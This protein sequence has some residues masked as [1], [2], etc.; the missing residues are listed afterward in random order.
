MYSTLNRHGR[1]RRRPPHLGYDTINLYGGSYGTRAALEYLRRHESHVRSVVIDGVAPTDLRLPLVLR[2]RRAAVARSAARRLRKRRAVSPRSIPTCGPAARA[3][4]K[5]STRTRSRRASSHPR[6]GVAD[7]VTV[8]G[9]LL[10]A[11][12][13][14][15]LYSPLARRRW[16][17]RSSN[18]RSA[19]TFRACSRCAMANDGLSDNMAIGMQMSVMCAEDGTRITPEQREAGEPVTRIFATASDR[20]SHEGL[21]VLA[22]SDN[23]AG[24]LRST[25]SQCPDADSLGRARSSHAADMGRAGAQ[26]AAELEASGRAGHRPWGHRDRRAACA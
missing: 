18:V 3:G 13:F 17:R 20:A 4:R 5:R 25:R 24:I 8:K 19:T 26:G 6:T 16:C 22:E 15:A 21:R 1:S 14:G 23:R 11:T 12:L 10:P 2:A 9:G 7:D